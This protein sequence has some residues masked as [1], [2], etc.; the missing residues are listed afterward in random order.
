MQE[1]MDAQLLV[2]GVQMQVWLTPRSS[3]ARVCAAQDS[4]SSR[5][6]IKHGQQA[7][8]LAHR[9]HMQTRVRV[10]FRR[11]HTCMEAICVRMSSTLAP[12]SLRVASRRR[13]SIILSISTVCPGGSRMCAPECVSLSG[14]Q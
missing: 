12:I 6:E 3:S 5:S 9:L 10:G 8:L 11:T 2:C 1:L 13:V 14:G 4:A 7:G